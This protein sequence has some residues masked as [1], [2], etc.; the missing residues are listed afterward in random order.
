MIEADTRLVDVTNGISDQIQSAEVG[1]S[2]AVFQS[3][4][5][6]SV[7]MTEIFCR[8]QWQLKG[9]VR[10]ITHQDDCLLEK[11]QLRLLL[12]TCTL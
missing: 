10:L 4:Y 9:V 2:S 1:Q 5:S 6:A 7:S 12:R 8:H 11:S 3:R